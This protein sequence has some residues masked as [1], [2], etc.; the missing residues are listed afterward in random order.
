MK[1]EY[2]CEMKFSYR[3]EPVYGGKFVLVQ[4]FGSEEGTGYGEG[5]GSVSGD[6][7]NGILRWVNHPH[8]R[9]DGMM[10]PDTHGVIITDKKVPIM[11]TL[12][13][14]TFFEEK[15]GKQLLLVNFEAEDE[16][17]RWLNREFCILEGVV[18]AE[19]FQ[20]HAKVYRCLHELNL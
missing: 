8:R 18:S 11:F 5:D 16:S 7:I 9:S 12:Q 15:T 3:N 13:G 20:M 10:L 19:T 17:Y 2:L 1:L 6:R 14:R 4:P